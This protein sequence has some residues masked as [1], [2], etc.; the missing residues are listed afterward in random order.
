MLVLS[1]LLHTEAEWKTYRLPMLRRAAVYWRSGGAARE[2]YSLAGPASPSSSP[3]VRPSRSPGGG[4][5]PS[6]SPLDPSRRL[7][8][9]TSL[10]CKRLGGCLDRWRGRPA[11]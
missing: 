1:L 6:R 4:G 8:Q 3:A 2:R 5:A 10:D 11:L 7:H 9:P